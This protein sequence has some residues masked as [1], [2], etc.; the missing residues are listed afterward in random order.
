VA[1][2]GLRL[3]FGLGESGIALGKGSYSEVISRLL[4]VVV[5]LGHDLGGIEGLGTIIIELLL[6]EVGLGVFYVGLLCLFR[7]DF[8]GNV[9]LGGGDGGLLAFDVGALLDVFNAGDLLASLDLVP[10]F[11]I[12]MR[13][14]SERRR[15][16]V[17]VGLWFDLAGSADGCDQVFASCLIGNHFGVSGLRTDYGKG[18]N[19]GDGNNDDNDDKNLLQAHIPMGGFASNHLWGELRKTGTNGSG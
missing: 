17:D 16:Q 14:S 10:F 1:A 3:G 2:S 5:L 19:G 11:Y 9:S 15:A 13:N 12:E 8:G 4:G 18:N 7:S 6:F